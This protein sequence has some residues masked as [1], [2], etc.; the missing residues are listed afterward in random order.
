MKI[1]SPWGAQ[2]CPM[3]DL[4]LLSMGAIFSPFPFLVWSLSFLLTSPPDTLILPC[5]S[6]P[7]FTCR[8]QTCIRLLQQPPY[9]LSLH[10]YSTHS[11]SSKASC[12]QTAVNYFSIRT[13][14]RP[15]LFS[16]VFSLFQ[17]LTV[18][19]VCSFPSLFPS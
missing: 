17:R 14:L 8:E 19:Y 7:H 12:I 15:S 6:Y 10:F 9:W 3:L 2:S 18:E 1:K 4:E 13:S 11:N 5:P 16:L